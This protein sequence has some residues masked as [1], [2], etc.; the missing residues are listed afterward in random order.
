[1][2]ESYAQLYTNKF[3]NLN[4]VDKFLERHKLSKLAQEGIENPNGIIISSYIEL[5]IPKLPKRKA[6]PRDGFVGKFYQTLKEL[7]STSQTLPK[8]RRGGNTPQFNL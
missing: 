1:M 3:N 2:I 7:T 8:N 5:V 4:Q 6:G